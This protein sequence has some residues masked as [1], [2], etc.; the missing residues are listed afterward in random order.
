[1][2]AIR[3]KRWTYV[4]TGDFAAAKAT[5]AK[6]LEYAGG[7]VEDPGW[8]LVDVQL[9]AP[10]E[11]R[12]AKLKLLEEAVHADEIQ[13]NPKAFAFEVALA[14]NALGQTEKA[15]DWLAKSEAAHGHSFNFLEVDPRIQNLKDELR[16]RKLLEKL[17][18]AR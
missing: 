11:D 7:S 8:R 10:N 15:L 9:T 17:R 2:P 6:E 1:M 12:A 3:V 16:F 13:R 18:S 5:F 14:Y 4:A